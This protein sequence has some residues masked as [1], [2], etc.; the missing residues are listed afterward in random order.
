MLLYRLDLAYPA[1]RVAVEYDGE[2]WHHLTEEQREN[3]R[4]RRE[5]LR[6]QG[7]TVIVVD[8]DGVHDRS[9]RWLR[10]LRE[11]LRP[12]T[13]RLRWVASS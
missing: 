13:R 9:Q 7:W 11:A 2:E 10:E 3:D 4:T 1:H 8:K 5:W 12:R 6:Q